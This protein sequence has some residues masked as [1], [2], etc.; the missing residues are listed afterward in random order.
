MFLPG[1]QSKGVIFELQTVIE[2]ETFKLS[3]FIS[4]KNNIRPKWF[5]GDALNP[6]EEEN[7]MKYADSFPAH[8][9]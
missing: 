9:S 1:E 7:G 4:D 6:D 2:A 3:R 5:N 8:F